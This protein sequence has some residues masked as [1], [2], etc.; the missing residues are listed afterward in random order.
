MDAKVTY[1]I[2]MIAEPPAAGKR[3]IDCYLYVFDGATMLAADDD[4]G[5]FPHARILFRPKKAG[6]YRIIATSLLGSDTG[7]YTLTVKTLNGVIR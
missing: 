7:P 4:G 6:Q 1:Q 2:D 5:G 3:M